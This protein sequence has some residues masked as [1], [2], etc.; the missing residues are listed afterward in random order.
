VD[1]ADSLGSPDASPVHETPD[2]RILLGLT[3]HIGHGFIPLSLLRDAMMHY[4]L[5][6]VN[7][8]E[9][10]TQDDAR[11]KEELGMSYGLECML[12]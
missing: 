5:S 12:R 4:R 3:K 9:L 10:D 1:A 6:Y 2:H 7:S 8:C 11:Y